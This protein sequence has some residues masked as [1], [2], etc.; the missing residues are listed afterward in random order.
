[1]A[2][3]AGGCSRSLPGDTGRNRNI[4]VSEASMSHVRQRAA[5]TP[6]LYRIRPTTGCGEYRRCISG[7]GQMRTQEVQTNEPSAPWHARHGERT[8][9]A[10]VVV[11]QQSFPS[12]HRHWLR[13]AVRSVYSIT[14]TRAVF[15]PAHPIYRAV[16]HGRR[17][18][19]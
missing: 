1:M 4:V 5:Q 3:V 2:K 13:S 19:R 16:R 10:P 11:H 18:W 9:A 17:A 7:W 8:A 6:P 15:L 12:G 14:S